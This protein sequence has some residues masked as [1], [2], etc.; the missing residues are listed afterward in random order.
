MFA[1]LDGLPGRWVPPTVVALALLGGALTLLPTRRVAGTVLDRAATPPA[2]GLLRVAALLAGT[3]V[4]IVLV[5]VLG[6]GYCELAKHVWLGSYALVVAGLVLAAAA[7]S[8]AA[9]GRT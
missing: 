1:Y 8:L 5:A 3:G 2:V 9:R 6:D 7:L 4:G